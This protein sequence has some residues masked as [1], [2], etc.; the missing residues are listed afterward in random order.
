MCI[1]MYLHTYVH[2]YICAYICTYICTYVHTYVPTYI[3]AY[4]GTYIHM[5]IHRYLHTYVHTYVP[6]YICTYIHMCML[7]NS[8]IHLRLRNVSIR[9]I[10][11]NA[12][13]YFKCGVLLLYRTQNSSINRE[14][15][16]TQGW[17]SLDVIF[18][19]DMDIETSRASRAWVIFE[20]VYSM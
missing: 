17:H 12:C 14:S 16:A 19:Q 11:L 6:T 13:T 15:D 2:T 7:W 18:K 3:C 10:S 8:W 1:H 4:I 9:Q 20:H 5:C